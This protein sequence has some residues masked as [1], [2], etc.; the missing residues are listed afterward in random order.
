MKFRPLSLSLL[1]MVMTA[2]PLPGAEIIPLWPGAVPGESKPLEN[3]ESL[4]V[5]G[6]DGIARMSNVSLPGMEWYPAPKETNTGTAIIVC[7]G[8]GY[9]ILAYEHEGSKVCEW[10]NSIGVNAVLLKYRVPRRANLP[11]QA[12]PLQDAQRAICLTRSRAAQWGIHPNRLG[13]LGFSAGGHLATCAMTHQGELTYPK[14]DAADDANFRP[15]FGI[16]VYPAY[17]QDDQNKDALS[18]EI[19]VT[20]DTPPAFI[21][22]A[23]DDRTFVEGSALLYLALRRNNVPAELHVFSEGGHGFG[24]KPTTKMVSTWTNR[25]ADWLQASGLLK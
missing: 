21:V 9:N 2:V 6:K 19:T 16:L 18:N 22:V 7:P 13:I 23:H 1:S 24:M 10:L 4:D 17:L 3:P 8:G 15:D 5:S 12:A 11:K 20:K 25:A 14:V